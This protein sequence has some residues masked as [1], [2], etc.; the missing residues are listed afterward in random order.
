MTEI[1]HDRFNYYC[2]YVTTNQL[3]VLQSCYLSSVTI[4]QS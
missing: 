2:L 3:H 1:I 4:I